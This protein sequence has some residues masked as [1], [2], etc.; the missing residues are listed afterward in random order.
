VSGLAFGSGDG[1]ADATMSFTGAL[2]D[3]NSALNGLSFNPTA[4]FSG[5]ASLTIDTDDQGNTGAGGAQTASNTINVTV[6]P[7]ASPIAG[8]D[9]YTVNED[10]ALSVA[11]SW[12]N[13]NWQ[14]REQLTFSN[15][16]RAENLVDFPVLVAIDTATSACRSTARRRLTRGPAPVDGNGQALAYEIQ[17]EHL[18]I[19]M[20]QG[21]AGRCLVQQRYDLGLLGQRCGERRAERGR[22][23]VQRL[24]RGVAP[25]ANAGRRGLD[26][27]FD[28]LRQQRHAIGAYRR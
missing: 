12:W 1:T 26:P 27:R 19:S 11:S 25:G 18:G 6:T 4:G 16:S 24:C 5:P 22:G 28:K 17:T 3:I 23:V 13:S 9:S 7:I 2:V 21:A 14:Y 15:A 20:G 8:N 10:A